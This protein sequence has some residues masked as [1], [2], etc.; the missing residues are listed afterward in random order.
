MADDFRLEI[1]KDGNFCYLILED[2]F[3]K[4][5]ENDIHKELKKYGVIIG[6]KD[7]LIKRITEGKY[8]HDKKFLIAE[9]IPPG[10]GKDGYVKY[11]IIEGYQE[12]NTEE[13][14][15]DYYEAGFIQSVEENQQLAEIVPPE[16]G[17]EGVNLFGASIS[18]LKGE[19]VN[20]KKV[21]GDN[22]YLSD[23]NRFVLALVNGVYQKN[24]L[25]LIYVSEKVIINSDL[26]FS[27]GNI[28]TTSAV[29]IKGDVKSGFSC[30]TTGSLIVEGVIEDAY[31]EVGESLVC[32]SGI[33]SGSSKIIVKDSIK[34]KYIY[35]R[36]CEC[37]NVYTQGMILNSTIY[38][39]NEIIAHK[40]VGGHVMARNKIIS[41]EI[42]NEKYTKTIVEV[43]VNYKVV[44]KMKE[45]TDVIAKYRQSLKD[46][47]L[48]LKKYEDEYAKISSQISLLFKN[49]QSLKQEV[50]EQFSEWAK[51]KD[52]EISKLKKVIEQETLKSNSLKKQ[53]SL[54]TNRI[55]EENTELKARKVIFPNSVVMI[56]LNGKY[57]VEKILSNVDFFLEKE[58]GKVKHR[59]IV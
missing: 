6:I 8:P 39:S 35:E 49:K 15:V 50:L 36:D 58:S 40:I 7:G 2:D 43:G 33:I 54:L 12:G 20:P 29:V 22:V 10:K 13:D 23:D 9:R 52:K 21:M 34:T 53:Y 18:G 48:L 31:I 27:V 14:Q 38:A 56:R 1:D 16:T 47:N 37:T 41:T 51:E 45:I 30:K 24:V 44:E 11:L 4:L 26:D 55:E 57:I 19:D 32:S 17:K 46:N 28:N 25:G 3:S 59:K 5:S 42:G